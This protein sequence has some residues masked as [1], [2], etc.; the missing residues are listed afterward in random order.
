MVLCRVLYVTTKNSDS[1]WSNKVKQ[2]IGYVI[3]V[4]YLS[5]KVEIETHSFKH[6]SGQTRNLNLYL[7]IFILRTFEHFYVQKLR[8]F[9]IVKFEVLYNCLI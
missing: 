1:T 3:T 4:I 5:T 6:E 8:V 9:F 7:N 2:N